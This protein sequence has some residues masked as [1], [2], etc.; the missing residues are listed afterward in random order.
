[1]WELQSVEIAVCCSCLRYFDVWGLQCVEVMVSGIWR[2][3]CVRIAVWELHSVGVLV[4]CG[5]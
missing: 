2:M 1:M 3:L 5:V 4:W